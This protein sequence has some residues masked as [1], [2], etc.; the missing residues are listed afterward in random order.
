MSYPNWANSLVTEDQIKQVESDIAEVEK[1][2]FGEIKI[3]I[4]ERSTSLLPIRF[5]FSQWVMV[6]SFSIYLF[7]A[8]H[9]QVELI[10]GL[11]ISSFLAVMAYSFFNRFPFLRLIT[12]DNFEQESVYKKALSEFYRLNLH[13]TKGQSSVLIFISLWEHRAVILADQ[14]IN[15]H[16]PKDYWDQRIKYLLSQIKSKQVAQG[17]SVTVKEI[18]GYLTQHFRSETGSKNEISNQIIFSSYNL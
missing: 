1:L 11:L 15:Q 4:C 14:G 9:Y 17:L 16:V 2:T 10:F 8:S 3:A 13:S 5:W 18:G 7:L 12:P 6:L